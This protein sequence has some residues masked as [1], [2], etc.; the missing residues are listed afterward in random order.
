MRSLFLFSLA[1]AL[2][3]AK[4]VVPWMCLERCGEDVNASLAQLATLAGVA[5][6]GVSYEA[7]QL[8]DNSSFADSGYSKVGAALQA[9]GLEAWP[10]VTSADIGKLRELWTNK[11]KFI[12]EAVLALKTLDANI[13]GYN[14]DFEPSGG[15]SPTNDDALEF[16]AFL[17]EFADALE[18]H[19]VKVAVNVA[20]WTAFWDY[21]ALEETSVDKFMTMDTYTGD[22]TLFVARVEN[23]VDA[24]DLEKL[25]IGI[26]TENPLST[27]PFDDAA[28]QLRFDTLA[29]HHVQE[30][31]IWSTPIPDSYIPFLKSFLSS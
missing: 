27:S 20:T 31:D 30:V 3:H 15:D 26:Q 29:K 7:F 10:M 11:Q 14:V 12:D 28:L 6:T 17:T 9:M 5:V 4:R 21:D 18:P 19:G 25:G 8:G 13:T 22:S 2:C 23:A 16:A 1:I 24:F